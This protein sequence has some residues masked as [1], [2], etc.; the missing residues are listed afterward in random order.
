MTYFEPETVHGDEREASAEFRVAA[1]GPAH[2]PLLLRVAARLP[3]SILATGRIARAL[4]VAG[5]S[6]GAR[7]EAPEQPPGGTG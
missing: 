3:A 6:A 1:I 2:R 5:L 7:Q 4:R